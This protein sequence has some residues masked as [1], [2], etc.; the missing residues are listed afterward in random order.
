MRH[1][2]LLLLPAF[3][4]HAWTPDR[5]LVPSPQGTSV[6]AHLAWATTMELLDPEWVAF[7]HP[8]ASIGPAAHGRLLFGDPMRPS[9]GVH[10][11]VPPRDACTVPEVAAALRFLADVVQREHP[12]GPDLVVG[13]I[14]QC[15]G[16]RFPPHRTHQS[17][18]DVDLRYYQLGVERGFHDYVFVNSTNFDTARVWSMVEAIHRHQL[19]EV[20]YIDY[21]HQ[22]RLYRYARA[23]RGFSTAALRPILSMPRTRRDPD[24]LVQHVPG[25]H[26]HLHIRFAAP[27]ARLFGAAWAP[28]AARRFQR[29]LALRR[30]GRYDHVVRSGETLA[31]IAR[32]NSVHLSDLMSWNRL[33]KRAVLRP[34]DVLEVRRP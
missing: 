15:G 10:V 33:S 3:S 22:R 17:G 18:R 26:N 13:D 1:A 34:G 31:M 14:S 9:R 16:G 29:A 8:A 5:L 2:L 25:H 6:V 32:R 27:L 4:A 24:A 30:D 21:R 7:A 12:G 20:V 28:G 19:A 23:Q 11:R